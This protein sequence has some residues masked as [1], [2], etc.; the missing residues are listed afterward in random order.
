M[1]AGSFV[2]IELVSTCLALLLTKSKFGHLGSFPISLLLSIMALFPCKTLLLLLGI[3]GLA[4]TLLEFEEG[5]VTL[6][7]E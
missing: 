5:Q 2:G 6:P 1:L 7:I 3:I 4:A